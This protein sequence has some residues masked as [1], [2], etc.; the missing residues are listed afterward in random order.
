MR[1]RWFNLRRASGCA[2][3]RDP[4]GYVWHDA[5]HACWRRAQLTQ[6]PPTRPRDTS[7]KHPPDRCAVPA[8]PGAVSICASL[9][10]R[11]HSRFDVDRPERSEF[12]VASGASVKAECI[13]QP[14]HRGTGERQ[15]ASKLTAASIRKTP[16][17]NPPTCS[18]LMKSTSTQGN[19]AATVVR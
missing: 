16:P 1:Y 17:K 4:R 3:F 9:A 19:T 2:P 11:N 6:R 5:V 18:D 10:Q 13:R 12:W 14:L 15:T 8:H 7:V